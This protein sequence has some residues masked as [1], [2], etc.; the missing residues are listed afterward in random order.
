MA[1]M[2]KFVESLPEGYGYVIFS[3]VGS[4]FV[5]MWM[6]INVGKARKKY[7]VEVFYLVLT[8]CFTVFAFSVK[9]RHVKNCWTSPRGVWHVIYTQK[10]IIYFL[11]YFCDFF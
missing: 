10:A 7:E 3:A 4:Q 1:G 8:L 11:E 2:S 9:G 6:A 5:A